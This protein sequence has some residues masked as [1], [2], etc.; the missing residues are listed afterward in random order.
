MSDEFR[1]S[2][3]VL[4]EDLDPDAVTRALGVAPSDSLRRG[5][6]VT[7]GARRVHAIGL[8]SWDAGAPATAPLA[9]HLARIAAR[10]GARARAI[11]DL[12]GAGLRVD[13]YCSYFAGGRLSQIR[14][15][16][17]ALGALARLGV[18]LTLNVYCPEDGEASGAQ[19]PADP[20]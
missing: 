11:G 14:L 20:P 10:F 12:A 13:V 8:W 16:P 18:A 19:P 5:D 2:L 1:V 6:P 9:E 7:R 17:D 15:E 4:G 3:R